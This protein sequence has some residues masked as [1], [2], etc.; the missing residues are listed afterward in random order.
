MTELQKLASEMLR[1]IERE[2]FEHDYRKNGYKCSTI[3]KFVQ[4]VH[5]SVK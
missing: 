4:K 5:R 2:N 3:A 1:T